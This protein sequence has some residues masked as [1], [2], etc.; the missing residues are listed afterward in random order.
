MLMTQTVWILPVNLRLGDCENLEESKRKKRKNSD[1]KR[2]GR[3][4]SGDVHFQKNNG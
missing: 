1:V 3:R 4:L 2:K